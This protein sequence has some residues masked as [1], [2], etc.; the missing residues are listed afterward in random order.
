MRVLGVDFGGKRIGLA[1]VDTT[2]GLPEPRGVLTASGT[3][4][5]DAEEIHAFAKR[6]NVEEVVVGLPLDQDGETKMS[7]VCRQLGAKI[8]SLGL[9]VKYVDESMTSQT[10]EDT[11]RAS[12]LKA[13][14]IKGRVD[15]EA[16]CHILER[17]LQG[18]VL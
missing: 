13:A 3:L 10:A 14:A 18:E 9:K 7:K 15:S 5:R 4:A 16:A 8:E 12:G 11:M 17:Y 2:V 1:T 6:D